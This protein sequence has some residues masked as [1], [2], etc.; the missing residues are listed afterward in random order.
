MWRIKKRALAENQQ[1]T[2]SRR[3]PSEQVASATSRLE[4]WSI[5]SDAWRA[6]QRR[7]E[8]PMSKIG[9]SVAEFKILRSLNES[10]PASMAKLSHDIVLTQPAIT[11]FVDKLE[12]RELVRRSR[13]SEDR[14]VINIMMTAK[15]EALFKRALKVHSSFVKDALGT[16]SSNEARQLST[17]MKKIAMAQR[18]EAPTSED[19]EETT[20]KDI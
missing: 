11:F 12:E 17:I 16:L 15:G 4:L 18:S 1:R 14:R 8:K 20:T 6:L 2:I 5:V 9:I 7:G 19:V 10:Q 3:K 13:D